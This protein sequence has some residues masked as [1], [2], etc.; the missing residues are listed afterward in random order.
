MKV[1]EAKEKA[2]YEERLQAKGP[3]YIPL[4]KEKSLVHLES[5][6]QQIAKTMAGVY[7]ALNEG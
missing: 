7:I 6:E 4:D 2:E 1:Q 5:T 3:E